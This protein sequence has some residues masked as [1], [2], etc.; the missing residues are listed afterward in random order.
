MG[1]TVADALGKGPVAL[2]SALEP[3]L[4]AE[5]ID[6]VG[7]VVTAAA[8]DTKRSIIAIGNRGRIRVACA[9]GV[10]ASS[11]LWQSNY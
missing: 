7:A 10:S 9:T 6:G 1:A 11:E 4:L 3:G 8:H 2:G 5:S